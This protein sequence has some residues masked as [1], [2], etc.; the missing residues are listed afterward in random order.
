MQIQTIFRANYEMEDP[1]ELPSSGEGV[2][3]FPP[4]Q[5]NVGHI[6]AKRLKFIDV[7]QNAWYGVFASEMD[8]L[9]LASTMPNPDWCFVS[10]AGTGYSLNVQRPEQWHLV[11][12]LPVLGARV[13]AERKC[14]LLNDFTRIVGYGEKGEMWRSDALCSDELRI[15]RVGLDSIW[16][17]GWDAPSG[18]RISFQVDLETGKRKA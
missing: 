17:T 5:A 4:L 13:E 10:A 2:I 6:Y 15:D 1:D 16:C 9:S 3:Y 8:G 11:P 12:V 7:A 14:V 18:E